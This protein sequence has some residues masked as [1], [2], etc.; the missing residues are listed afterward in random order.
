MA[1]CITKTDPIPTNISDC[2][3]YTRNGNPYFLLVSE[4]R[5][6]L[7]DFDISKKKTWDNIVADKFLFGRLFN[8]KIMTIED[9]EYHIDSGE[10]VEPYDVIVIT[11]DSGCLSIL[12]VDIQGQSGSF[13]LLWQEKL[14]MNGS[15]Y[16]E[17]GHLLAVDPHYNHI[18][19]CAFESK[20]SIYSTESKSC[21]ITIKV[22]G[23]IWNMSFVYPQNKDGTVK[24]VVAHSPSGTL[25]DFLVSCFE[26]DKTNP[27]RVKK[28]SACSVSSDYC[29]LEL[30]ALPNIPN[31]FLLTTPSSIILLDA[32]P[33]T[34]KVSITLTSAL[35]FQS[36]YDSIND[37][38]G[39]ISCHIIDSMPKKGLDLSQTLFFATDTGTILQTI[40]SKETIQSKP[41][42]NMKLSVIAKYHNPVGKMTVLSNDGNVIVL[43]LFGSQANGEIVMIK[44]KRQLI[45][46]WPARTIENKAP[47]HDYYIDSN[48]WSDT[49]YLATGVYPNGV[50]KEVKSGLPCES[51]IL[52]DYFD[53]PKLMW[54]VNINC[55]T[56]LHYVLV[57]SYPGCTKVML[58]DQS[59]MEDI[60]DACGVIHN[61]STLNAFT[62]DYSATLVQIT[63]KGVTISKMRNK[64]DGSMMFVR[65]T[66]LFNKA[67]YWKPTTGTIVHGANYEDKIVLA[68]SNPSMIY[69]LRVLVDQ[70]NDSLAIIELSQ[71]EFGKEISSLYIPPFSDLYTKSFFGEPVLLLASY[72]GTIEIVALDS[73]KE[74]PNIIYTI[75]L[76]MPTSNPF[77]IIPHSIGVISN[78]SR[79]FL[80]IGNRNGDIVYYQ[81]TKENGIIFAGE[82]RFK[83]L[84]NLPVKLIAMPSTNYLIAYS[85]HRPIHLK[86]SANKLQVVELAY[87]QFEAGTIIT[88][89]VGDNIDYQLLVVT[90]NILSIIQIDYSKNE[91]YRKIFVENT[92]KFLVYDKPTKNL[93]VACEPVNREG[94]WTIKVIEPTSG[95]CHHT[96]PLK[97]QE[98]SG[99]RSS[100]SNMVQYKLHL[101]GKSV[102]GP[103]TSLSD[104][105]HYLVAGIGNALVQ[106]KI[107]A[108]DRTIVHGV[109]TSLNHPANSLKTYE[110]EIYLASSQDSTCIYKFSSSKKSIDFDAGEVVPRQVQDTV[111]FPQDE[112]KRIIVSLLTTGAIA[113]Y[114]FQ[115][116]EIKLEGFPQFLEPLFHFNLQEPCSKLC[117]GSTISRLSSK[118][119][120]S[121]LQSLDEMDFDVP[122]VQD[123]KAVVQVVSVTGTRFALVKL[124]ERMFEILSLLQNI[125]QKWDTTKPILGGSHKVFRSTEF[126][127]PNHVIDG[128]FVSQFKYLSSAERIEM[129]LLLNSRIKV[130]GSLFDAFEQLSLGERELYEKSVVTA[131]D[132]DNILNRL[133]SVI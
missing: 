121:C 61:Q 81:F 10:F 75:Q 47:V 67:K 69:L 48:P 117:F 118:V 42:W 84:G 26:F 85:N 6:T 11:S 14:S 104:F 54:G 25:N 82:V 64:E 56:T 101:P 96:F 62:L 91:Q 60:T 15:L 4:F 44:A 109:Q 72:D 131:D 107:Q 124:S 88:Q 113:G 22:E 83:N 90:E 71:I 125:L 19:V 41:S 34:A 110:N 27:K 93:V 74:S 31:S 80:I 120:S 105:G 49:M 59:S 128:L 18:A 13:R 37:I 65:G 8:C 112:N 5:L 97:P 86:I 77:F 78:Q 51:S 103:I 7:V 16:T 29:P 133:D 114:L 23:V 111:V 1:Y 58:M 24:F 122:W 123:S 87:E 40:V 50:I 45:T 9:P 92:P 30:I 28:Y 115:N 100:T 119:D 53:Q 66:E 98:I 68:C 20:L 127:T 2:L 55:F 132:L 32:S 46:F 33:R 106:I 3:K 70:T 89:T 63:A 108:S 76:Q 38:S 21:E 95:T 116:K 52:C 102:G 99:S 57:L 43:S 39:I 94:T 79:S 35:S 129:V 12:V 17:L 73:L 130:N 126:G 36:Q